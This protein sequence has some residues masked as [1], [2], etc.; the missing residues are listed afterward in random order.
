M[1]H[2]ATISVTVRASARLHMGFLDL[3][4][5]LGRRFGSLG[6]SL[7]ELATTLT[8]Y[9]ADQV[10]AE[11]P[12]SERVESF[13]RQSLA[14]MGIT[15]GTYIQVHQAIPDHA[16]L[17]SG[18]QLALAVGTA[19]RAPATSTSRASPLVPTTSPAKRFDCPR[20]FA[21]NAVRGRS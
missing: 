6:L 9:P 18:T 5:G 3:N 17:G 21:T 13:A 1:P 12:Q 7:D 19:M 8:A 11:G 10:S 4:G 20:K 15:D 16:G 14:A 2:T